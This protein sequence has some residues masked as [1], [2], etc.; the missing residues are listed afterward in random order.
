MADAVVSHTRCRGH[1][2][3]KRSH[4]YLHGHG[5]APLPG[6]PRGFPGMLCLIPLPSRP[7][8]R[9]TIAA[10][11]HI[12]IAEIYEA[13][14]VDIEKVRGHV[15]DIICD[16]TGGPGAAFPE[17]LWLSHPGK[18]SR[19]SC[20]RLGWWKLFPPVEGDHG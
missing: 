14:L 18:C 10:K 4:R 11:H 13:E 9:F 1:Q 20:S 3:L 17:N 16:V 5:K 15:G 8:G 12:T 6:T 2:L 19:P 7:Q